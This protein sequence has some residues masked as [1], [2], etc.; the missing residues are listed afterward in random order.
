M[1]ESII[2]HGRLHN[3]GLPVSRLETA[4]GGGRWNGPAGGPHHQS[5][6]AIQLAGFTSFTRPERETRSPTTRKHETDTS[7]LI[8]RIPSCRRF[9]VEAH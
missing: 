6:E 7:R 3:Y 4:G 2:N 5:S 8:E 1:T 9:H